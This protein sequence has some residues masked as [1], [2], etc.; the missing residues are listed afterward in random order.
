M[1]GAGV[2]LVRRAVGDVAVH[3]DQRRPV[4]RAQEGAEGP[5]QH[6]QVVGVADAGDVPAVADEARGHVVAEGQRGVA[7]DGDVVVVVDPAE[8]GELQVAGERG[9]LGR[10]AFHHAAV[11]AQGVD[12]EVDQVLEAGLVEVGGH[13]AAGDGHA[14]AVGQPLPERAGGGLDAAGPAVLRVAGTAA[15]EL[16]EAL[17]RLQR[18][19]RL[20]QRLVVL[21]DRLH[22]R[23]VQQRVQQ[24]RGV[25]GREDEAVAVGPDRVLRVEA[26][27][28]LPQA[29]GHGRQGHRRARVPG[30]GRLDGVHRQRADRVDARRIEIVSI[31]HDFGF[32]TRTPSFTSIRCHRPP[33]PRDL[34]GSI[35]GS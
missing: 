22:P 10:D 7:L 12:V 1:G 19:R 28:L 4:A 26:Q 14:D 15:V 13:P 33:C 35:G 3:D 25:A 30:V 11:A 24:H 2:L 8:V 29:V 21:A 17:D 9:R 6:L 27:E 31:L 18:H 34:I 20:A 32:L 5:R 16:P 23:Q